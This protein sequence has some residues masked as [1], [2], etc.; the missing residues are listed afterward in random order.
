M[1]KPSKI[2]RIGRVVWSFL[3]GPSS[4]AGFKAKKTVGLAKD[5]VKAAR[6]LIAERVDFWKT[7]IDQSKPKVESRNETFDEA[8]ARHG[9]SE[10]DIEDLYRSLLIKNR[11]EF[12]SMYLAFVGALTAVFFGGLLGLISGFSFTVV[13]AVMKSRTS[14]RL[15][16]VEQRTLISFRSFFANHGATRIFGYV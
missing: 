2:K 3:D 1:S 10:A 4:V 12:F 9:L 8:M 15:F 5:E 6:G 13:F 7:E 14:F 16:Q 11:I